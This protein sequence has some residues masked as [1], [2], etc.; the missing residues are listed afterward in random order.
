[1][2]TMNVSLPEALRSFVESQVT[3]QHYGS[4]SEYVRYLIRRDQER[5]ALRQLLLAGAAS[6][7]TGPADEAWF[8]RVRGQARRPLDG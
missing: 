3:E 5:V 1:M 2:S 8:D 7:P 4:T 6:E